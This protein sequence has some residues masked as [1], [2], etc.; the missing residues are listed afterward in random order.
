[1]YKYILLFSFFCFIYDSFGQKRTQSITFYIEAAKKN[2]PLLKD[3]INQQAIEAYEQQRLKA[4]YTHSKLELNGSCLFVPVISKDDGRTSFQWDAQNGSNYYGYDLSTSST[5]LLTGL[6]WNKSLTGN[7]IY[8]AAYEQTQ[9]RK[10]LLHNHVMMEEHQLERSVTEQYILCLLDKQQLDFSDSIEKTLDKQE[11]LVRRLA[12]NGMSK[13]SDLH[14]IAIEKN[15][16]E[17]LAI[18]SQQSYHSHLIDL[19]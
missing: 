16:N 12:A 17:E 5:Q 7:K 14:L 15:N 8:Q 10:D 18:T 4:F 13:Q 3:Y 9:V 11:E 6:T 1:M 19:N 2:S